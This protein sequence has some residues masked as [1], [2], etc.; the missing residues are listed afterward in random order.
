[1]KSVCFSIPIRISSLAND[2]RHWAKK[3]KERKNKITGLNYYLAGAGSFDLP[4]RVTFERVAPR[5]LDAHDNLPAALKPYTDCVAD[6]LRPGMRAGR[7]DDTD[8][9]EW[10]YKQ[11]QGKPR[12]YWLNVTI[13]E[14][15]E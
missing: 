13:E 8:Q 11:K 12:E 7:A 10:I 1:M 9:I 3:W 5:M 4:V 14:I 2:S 6:F 15:K